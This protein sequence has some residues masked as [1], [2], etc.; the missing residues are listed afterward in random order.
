MT[1]SPVLT[2]YKNMLKLAKTLP[3]DKRQKAIAD[4][5][6]Q[7]RMNA[8]EH[9]QEMVAKLLDHAKSSLSYLKMVT[10][11]SASSQTGVTRIVFGG[12][13]KKESKAVSNW[14]GKNMDPDAVK[15]HYNGLKRAGFRDNS[16]AKGGMF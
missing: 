4:I 2:V 12:D 16:H 11:K 3:I 10:P 13:G 7:F 8:A 6:S 14:S 5:R 1:L 15:R 9:N